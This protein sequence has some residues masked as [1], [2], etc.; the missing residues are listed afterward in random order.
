[1]T[2]RPWGPGALEPGAWSLRRPKR[3]GQ[4]PAPT[5]RILL[6][7]LV[8]LLLQATRTVTDTT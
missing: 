4:L 3:P 1:M 8:V 5:G 2:R 7:P 6:G